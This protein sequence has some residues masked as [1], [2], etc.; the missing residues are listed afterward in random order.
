[1]EEVAFDKPTGKLSLRIR[2]KGG[3]SFVTQFI[4]TRKGVNLKG[5]PRLN[6]E[7]RVVETT[8][9]YRTASGPQIGEVFSEVKGD[10]PTYTLGG[11]ELY[12]RAIITSSTTSQVTSS[13]FPFQRA[14]T[15]PVGWRV[16][17][18]E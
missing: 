4:G 14:W 18:A 2:S 7:G 8:L 16:P 17:V 10:N 9:D 1:L 15:Q 11:D 3:E 12:V 6:K 13:E 5:K